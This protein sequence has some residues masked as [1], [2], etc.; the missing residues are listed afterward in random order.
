MSARDVVPTAGIP[1]RVSLLPP[2]IIAT[3]H[4]SALGRRLI[5]GVAGVLAVSLLAVAGFTVLAS[6]AQDDLEL[7]QSETAPLLKQQTAFTEASDLET[8]LGTVTAAQQYG[9]ATEVNW[10]DYLGLIATMMPAG[11]T[12]TNVSTLSAAP[13]QGAF[14]PAGPLRGESS[15][16]FQLEV[17]AA[18]TAEVTAWTR[19]L[20][21]LPGYA[22]ASLDT[23]SVAD[24]SSVA[25]TVTAHVTLNVTAAAHSGRFAAPTPEQPEQPTDSPATEAT[26][27]I[28]AAPVD[29]AGK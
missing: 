11:M 6:I 5:V 1:P 19:A 24:D 14:A 23:V 3:A 25:P 18:S 7:A 4:A 26:A 22:D 15:A 2:E 8:L 10:A 27:T 21:A 12:L 17:T 20:T 9:A 28:P 13:W 16:S 29:Q